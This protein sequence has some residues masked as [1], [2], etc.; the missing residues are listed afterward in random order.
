V[1]IYHVLD[2]LVDAYCYPILITCSDQTCCE[3]MCGGWCVVVVV[4]CDN[5][6]IAT[7]VFTNSVVTSLGRTRMHVL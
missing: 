4:D 5:N 7:M 1:N 6:F 2:V 3:S